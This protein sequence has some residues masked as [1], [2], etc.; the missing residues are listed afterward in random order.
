MPTGIGST[1]IDGEYVDVSY[2]A[3]YDNPTN[4]N[5]YVAVYAVFNGPQIGSYSMG[6][7]TQPP[8][9]YKSYTREGSFL[10]AKGHYT[11]SIEVH[12]WYENQPGNQYIATDG[13]WKF[14]LGS[15]LFCNVGGIDK[16]V[17][18]VYVNIGGAWKLAESVSVNVGGEWKYSI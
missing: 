1:S 4:Y 16:N 6:I 3:T 9:E 17:E 8:L 11:W 14:Q 13:D 12:Y 15:N 18:S 10:L 7:F 2:V 5:K